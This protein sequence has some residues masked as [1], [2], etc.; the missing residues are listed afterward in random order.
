[1]KRFISLALAALLV[2]GSIS[3]SFGANNSIRYGYKTRTLNQYDSTNTVS[4]IRVKL[5]V[6]N[7]LGTINVRLETT[8]GTGSADV[9]VVYLPDSKWDSGSYY[10]AV[11]GT[12]N[13]SVKIYDSSDELVLWND[14]YSY[15]FLPLS[16]GIYTSDYNSLQ[17]HFLSG[18]GLY[19]GLATLYYTASDLGYKTADEVR[20]KSPA[21][22]KMTAAGF[23]F[24]LALDD[25]TIEYFMEHGTLNSYATFGWPGLAELIESVRYEMPSLAA[26]Q[27]LKNFTK[28]NNY[29]SG[30]FLDVGIKNSAWYDENVKTVY[31][32]GLMQ[33]DA[34]YFRPQGELTLAQ[35]IAMAARLHNIYNGGSGKFS[36][37]PVWYSVYINYAVKNGI[38]KASDFGADTKG[39][40]AYGR[41]ATRG[42]MA[43]IFAS[44]MPSD[45][46][47]R[48]NS[49]KSIPDVYSTTRY[50]DQIFRL[51]EAGIL[52]GSN[53][54]RFYPYNYVTRAEAAA[55]IS[56]M[57]DKD[58][59][60]EFTIKELRAKRRKKEKGKTR[61]HGRVFYCGKA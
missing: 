56:R 14:L 4:G 42:E 59:R 55:T 46:L 21:S 48:I 25:T 22:L 44:A 29:Y 53:G 3:F 61:P 33:G 38:I 41:N 1:M 19:T 51:Y 16:G 28:K 54:H 40:D 11:S 47:P 32:L 34:G 35:A 27:A 18:P 60:L 50:R 7:Y 24:I 45:A 26:E 15:G 23:P 10:S 58:L 36:E 57:A 17:M 20:A 52:E 49:I 12:V 2:L 43:Y 9:L 30:I 8:E 31:Q 37:G 39:S 13:S 6:P 5:S